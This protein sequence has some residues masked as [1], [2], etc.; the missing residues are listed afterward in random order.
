[1]PSRAFNDCA[2][3]SL[4]VLL[5]MDT[6]FHSNFLCFILNSNDVSC[7]SYVVFFG[8]IPRSGTIRFKTISFFKTLVQEK[9]HTGEKKHSWSLK[10]CCC[11]CLLFCETVLRSPG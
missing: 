7:A 8:W 4:T 11:C 6:G 5:L 9:K 10:L 1:M 2:T 3:A